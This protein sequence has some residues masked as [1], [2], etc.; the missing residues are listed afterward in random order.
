[1]EISLRD[2]RRVRLNSFTYVFKHWKTCFSTFEKIIVGFLA[3]VILATSFKWV[4]AASQ[5]GTLAP[6][7]GGV[8]IEGVTG[9]SLDDIDLGRLTKS[10]LVQTAADGT[11]KPDLASSWQIGDDKMTYT[12]SMV[13]SISSVEVVSILDK[14]P[15]YIS[16]A[17]CDTSDVQTVSCKL[18]HPNPEFLTELSKPLFP[19]GPYKLDKK[20][21][22]EIRLKRNNEYH[23]DRPFIDQFIIRSYPDQKA[24]EKAAARGK[25]TAALDLSSVPDGWS[26]KTI[27]LSKEHILFINSLKSYLK[28]VDVRTQILDANKPDGVETLTI[29]EVNGVS[30]DAEYEAFKKKL[31]DAGVKLV[32][33]KESLKDALLKDLP[34][35]NY[36]ILYILAS[37]SLS[38]DPYKYWN[39]AVRSGSGQNFAE[40]ADARLDKLTEQ[41]RDSD[42]PAKKKEILDSIND[43]ISK[44]KVAVEY[45]NIS[46]NYFVSPRVMGV[47]LNKGCLCET[48][49]FDQVTSW[50]MKEKRV[51]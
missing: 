47:V 16:N 12:F 36:D 40:V 32:I 37:S 46:A 14:N 1:M 8:F 5:S 18:D 44:L 7:Y 25:I 26:K 20:T 27:S 48:D 3:L 42:D 29:L 22:D 49:R 21:K 15:T 31:S 23:L 10:G 13:S 43:T 34:E 28:K 39:S 2:I 50:Y 38:S 45:N 9:Q 19:Y 24:L 17:I 11:I 6:A 4:Q 30:V 35:R 51:K 41:Y 33:K